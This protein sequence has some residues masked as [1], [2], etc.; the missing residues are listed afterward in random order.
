MPDDDMGFIRVAAISP[1]L[2]LSHPKANALEI[3][4]ALEQA[5]T[6]DVAIAVFP[7]MAITGYT[8]NDLFHQKVLIQAS[9]NALRQVQLFTEDGY[10]GLAVVGLPVFHDDQLFNCAAVI[11]RGKILGIVP[12][13]YLP[14]YRE[15]YDARY[16]APANTIV[17]NH[18]TLFGSEV[19]FGVDLLFQCGEVVFGLEIC[20]DLWGPI[21]PSSILATHGALILANLSASNETIAK[22]NYRKDLV[23]SQSARCQ[24]VY[25]YSSSGV[26]ESSTDLVFGGQCLIAENGVT[27]AETKRFQKN[28]QFA[29]ADVDYQ[30]LQHNRMQT[31]SFDDT[32]LEPGLKRTMRTIA[33]E[34]PDR[35]QSLPLQRFV[36]GHPFVPSGPSELKERCEEIFA[37]QTAALARRLSHANLPT[38]SIGVSGGLDSTLALLVLCATLDELGLPRSK[39]RAL[40]M[41]GFGTSAKTR[42][43]AIALMGAL[44]VTHDEID[45]CDLCIAEML[46]LKVCPFGIDLAGLDSAG[47]KRR[48]QDLPD[49]NRYDL[50]FENVQARMRTSLLMNSGFVIGTGDLS[51]L[52]LGWCTYNAD[53]MSMYNVNVSIPKTLVRFLVEWAAKNQFDGQTQKILLEIAATEIS[54]ELLPPDRQGKSQSTESSV[55]PYEL[56]DFFLYYF[57]RFG[58]R[59]KKILYLACQAKFTQSYTQQELTHWLKLFLKRFFAAQYKRS[60][61]PDGPKVGSVSL[62]P[63]GDWR[64]PSDAQ[65]QAWLDDL[66]TKP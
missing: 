11:N 12:K 41:P 39:I 35:S 5:Q 46:A 63:R 58:T 14:N 37:I 10:A 15:F 18:E 28:T 45:I 1:A 53:H 32:S 64:M 65:V 29:I 8:C 16:F 7:E 21:P 47:L 3:I 4:T 43:N 6:Q 30:R 36:S 2:A 13:T 55:G 31:T 61:I 48:L 17:T 33:F 20:E 66:E 44:G 62:S 27:L 23:E 22:A 54:P 40:T 19:P 59:P 9:L 49:D 25:I 34:L 24:A 50:T 51:E 52:A 26:G 56:V 38:P 57:L 60:C 42:T